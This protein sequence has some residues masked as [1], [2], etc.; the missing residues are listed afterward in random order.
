MKFMKSFWLFQT[1]P[2]DLS[3][4][5]TAFFWLWNVGLVLASAICL[6]GVSLLFAYGSY[7]PNLFYSYFDFPLILLLNLAPVVGLEVLLWC[8]TGR[9]FLA[10]L[11]TGVITVGFSVG[12]YYKLLFR[13]DPLMF[14][15]M[16]NIREALS[17]TGT[18]SYD[19]TP[20]KRIIFGVLCVVFG[21]L[22]L[23]FI[24]RGRPGKKTRAAL[25]AAVLLACVP[26]SRAYTSDRVFDTLTANYEFINRWAATQNFI[27]KGFVY[28]FLHSVTEGVVKAPE[29]YR[30]AEAEALLG[31][32]ETADIPAEKKVDLIT[33]QLEAFADFSRFEGLE[34][35]D[36][37]K[38]YGVY[39]GIAA[40]HRS[41]R[42]KA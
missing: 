39:H 42:K 3:R 11:I 15:D 33:L 40:I 31:A 17:I 35:I 36:F 41:C 32:Y 16:K 18:A 23:V 34:G 21:T 38:A 19:L 8:L 10:F 12:H 26:A 13:D 4:G 7:D 30:E 24:A 1:T 25:G 5:K 2:N 22:V 20:D 37:E 27:S 9:S 29:G 6:G 14:L 28:P